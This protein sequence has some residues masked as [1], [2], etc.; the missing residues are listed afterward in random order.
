MKGIWV[1]GLRPGMV[2]SKPVYIDKNNLLVKAYEP[3]TEAD[4]NRLVKWGIREVYC[5]GELVTQVQIEPTQQVSPEEEILVEN[6]KKGIKQTVKQR[7]SLDQL[8]GNGGKTLQSVYEYLAKDTVTQISPVRD[9]A[10]KIITTIDSQIGLVIYVLEYLKEPNLYRHAIANGILATILGRGLNFSIPKMIEIIFSILLMD[11]GMLKISAY[12][13]KK[14]DSLTAQEK[15]EV[16]KHTLLGY[17]ILTGVA[18]IKANLAEVALQHHEHYDGSG[19][20]RKIKGKDMS[21]ASRLASI[22]DSYT[23]MIEHKPYR[24]AKLPY[25]AIR[26]LLTLGLYRYDPVYLKTFVDRLS[27]YPLGSVV[28]LSNRSVGIVVASSPGKPIRPVV[29]AVRSDLETPFPKA[30]IEPLAFRPELFI[31]RALEPSVI[32]LSVAEELEKAAQQF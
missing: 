10:E 9:L 28:E 2:F 15:Y 3:I 25:E 29:L 5:D 13:N 18:K 12:Q 22:V 16:Q 4:I 20:P 27:M 8:F 26:E 6:V 31:T 30:R 23:A 17:Q 24:K 21:E 14:E 32:R 11:V 1:R 7:S 19:Y